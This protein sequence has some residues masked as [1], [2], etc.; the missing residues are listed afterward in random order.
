VLSPRPL[1]PAALTRA[2]VYHYPCVPADPGGE[3]TPPSRRY[4]HSDQSDQIVL[5]GKRNTHREVSVGNGQSIE[6]KF[7]LVPRG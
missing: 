7:L 4:N 2:W 3:F 6:E 1:H 5:A